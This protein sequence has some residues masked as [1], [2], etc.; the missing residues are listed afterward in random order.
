MNQLLWVTDDQ[1]EPVWARNGSYQAVRFNPLSRRNVGSHAAGRSNRL[2]FGREKLSGAPLGMQHER[3]VPDYAPLIPDGEVIALDAHIRLANPRTPETASSLM[4][5]R[6]YSYSA[7]ISASGQ[8]G[9]G[10][11]VR[12]LS[13]TILERGLS[14]GAAAPERRSAG[15]IYPALLAAVTFLFWPGVPDA[16]HYLGAVVCWKPE[17]KFK[18]LWASPFLV[19]HVFTVFVLC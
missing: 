2:S 13:A 8:A 14:H 7:G 19:A 17:L 16:S 15:R 4:L 11:A 5:R 1:D 10:V 9:D 3:D 12:L 6:G 18:P